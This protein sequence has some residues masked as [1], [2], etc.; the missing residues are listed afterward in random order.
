MKNEIDKDFGKD[1]GVPD[2]DKKFFVLPKEMPVGEIDKHF[3]V[4]VDSL[5]VKK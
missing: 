1:I 3:W 2:C 4:D 5:V